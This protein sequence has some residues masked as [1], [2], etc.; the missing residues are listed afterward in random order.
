MTTQP[1]FDRAALELLTEFGGSGTYSQRGSAT[2]DPST[3]LVSS[4]P[5][6]QT[7]T[8]ALFDNT[9]PNNGFGVKLGTEILAADKEAYMI[10]PQKNG[11]TV[12]TIDPVND[13]ITVG[14]VTYSIVTFKEV[15]P[16]GADP[17]LYM[18]YLRR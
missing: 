8:I 9:R 10:P 12:M 11:G 7:V 18:F 1:D 17:I 14:G 13:N 5:F 16:S 3:G 15:N 4:T 6:S 2:Y